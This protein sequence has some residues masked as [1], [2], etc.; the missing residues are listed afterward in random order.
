MIKIQDKQDRKVLSEGRNY[1]MGFAFLKKLK[2]DEY[3]TVQP[4]SPC[5]DYL[6]DV[7]Y[8]EVLDQEITACGL[9]YK[10][11]GIF[12]SEKAYLTM[13]ICPPKNGFGTYSNGYTKERFEKDQEN[14]NTNL[15]KITEVINWIEQQI[16]VKLSKI[17]KAND[18]MYLIEAPHYWAESTY[19]IS[20]YTLLLRMA[21]YWDGKGTV[22]DFLNNFPQNN[23]ESNMWNQAKVKL[24]L[25][26]SGYTV[27]Q[28]FDKKTGGAIH[29]YGIL[30]CKDFRF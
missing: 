15:D 30:H 26:M 7:I 9:K 22:K 12:D 19:L 2:K 8:S 25:F 14:L 6:N 28:E 4:I 21:Q 13:K 27:K 29:S 5:K 10:K 11:H 24:M 18:D 1:Q 3:E 16:G 17:S 20:L 23:L